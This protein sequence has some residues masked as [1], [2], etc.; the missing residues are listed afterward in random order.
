[1]NTNTFVYPT[2]KTDLHII[3]S[4]QEKYISALNDHIVLTLNEV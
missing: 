1:M 4:S 3:Q 2:V